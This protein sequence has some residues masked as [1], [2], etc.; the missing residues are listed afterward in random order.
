[1]SDALIKYNNKVYGPNN[2]AFKLAN[3]SPENIKKDVNIGGI[4]GTFEGDVDS[5]IAGLVQGTATEVSSQS[6]TSVRSY[7]FQNFNTVRRIDLP[8][9]TSVDTNSF[10]SAYNLEYLN[11][12]KYAPTSIGNNTFRGCT[13]VQTFNMDSSNITSIGTDTFYQLASNASSASNLEITPT[14]AFSVGGNAF[15]YAKFKKLTGT[16]SSLG[17]NAFEYSSI[18]DGVDVIIASGVNVNSYSFNNCY[19]TKFH[20]KIINGYISTSG[21]AYLSSVSDFELDKDSVITSLTTTAFLGLGSNRRNPSETPISIDMRNSTYTSL[22]TQLFSNSSSTHPKYMNVYFPNT[23]TS[24]SN[25]SLISV[26]YTNFFFTGVPAFGSNVLSYTTSVKL[27]VPYN[28]INEAKTKSGWSTYASYIYGWSEENTF[29]EGDIL[30]TTNSEGLTLT[31]YSDANLTT[32]VT[33]VSDATQIY[34]CRG[35]QV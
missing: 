8:E 9:V 29:Q 27:F 26:Q 30:P 12:P 21:L 35:R 19:T 24:V 13:H 25:Q 15:K 5:V 31:W 28:N 20:I 22:P 6:A 1:M 18:T 3:L 17:S 10:Y 33:T 34:Y 14:N 23:V 16:I 32:Q 4:V 2:N 11:L 7:C